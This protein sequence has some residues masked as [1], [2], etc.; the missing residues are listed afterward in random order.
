MSELDDRFRYYNQNFKNVG[1]PY[2]QK[3]NFSVMKTYKNFENN[4]YL[5]A[6]AKGM[7]S[8]VDFYKKIFP[9]L[10]PSQKILITVKD[11]SQIP[12]GL[13]GDKRFVFVSDNITDFHKMFDTYIY[14]HKGYI[15]PHPRL[16]HECVFYGKKIIYINELEIKDGG[17]YR[18]LDALDNGLKNH[19]LDETDE[20]IQLMKTLQD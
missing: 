5:T 12:D 13:K 8:L 9:L 16:F 17:Y 20:I 15:D 18:Y 4:A 6:V 14:I 1:T 19:T 10:Q 2:Y 11:D 3:I 7:P